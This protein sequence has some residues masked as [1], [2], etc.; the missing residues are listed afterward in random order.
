MKALPWVLLG[1]VAVGGGAGFVWYHRK[2]QGGAA[3]LPA[4]VETHPEQIS[5]TIVAKPKQPLGSIAKAPEPKK[6]ATSPLARVVSTAKS[7]AT[8][9]AQHGIDRLTSSFLKKIG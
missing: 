9:V 2:H 6:G 5:G 8:R 3:A 1:I 4:V 7:S